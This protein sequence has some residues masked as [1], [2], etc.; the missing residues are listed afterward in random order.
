MHEKNKHP[1]PAAAAIEYDR[2]RDGATRLTARG[3]G[4][5]AEK[6]IDCAIRHGVP[7]RRDPSLVEVLSRLH[8]NEEI[9]P[10]LYRA[11][12][13]ILAFLYKMNE[14]HREQSRRP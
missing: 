7:V 12:A 8:I 14:K 6:I 5:I 9:P 2:K 11:V 3:R 13:E 4:I 1:L 10:E